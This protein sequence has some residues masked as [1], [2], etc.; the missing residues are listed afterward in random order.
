MRTQ[1]C[2]KAA[3]A[4]LIGCS[5]A[6]TVP[7][8][9]GAAAT[10][11][12]MA[13][14]WQGTVDLGE[15]PCPFLTCGGNL[16]ATVVG[17]AS[18]QDAQGNAFTV[19]WPDPTSPTPPLPTN[20]TG[21]FNYSDLCPVPATGSGS[22]TYTLSG[23]YVKDGNSASHDG[24]L[25]GSFSVLRIGLTLIVTTSGGVLT[26][27]GKTLATQQAIGGFPV[28]AAVGVLAPLSPLNTCLDIAPATAVVA[29]SFGEPQ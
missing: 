5:F 22:G 27:A 13:A 12:T 18:G 11:I 28:G 23:G 1:K 3:A 9:H 25:T 26:G 6:T 8:S 24:T 4:M 21:P 17:D 29:G 16:Y 14:S 10:G 19:I 20:L 2:P 7:T 15:Y